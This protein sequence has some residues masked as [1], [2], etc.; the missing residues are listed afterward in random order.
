MLRLIKKMAVTRALKSRCRR[1]GV[2]LSTA[3]GNARPEHTLRNMCNRIAAKRAKK[4]KRG[5]CGGM[6]LQYGGKK[7]GMFGYGK[8]GLSNT[9][10]K[11]QMLKYIK[12]NDP[13]GYG[14]WNVGKLH[15][16][17][18]SIRAT[19]AHSSVNYV[20]GIVQAFDEMYGKNYDALYGLNR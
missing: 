10:V 1:H 19:G 13:I 4:A 2:R 5:G 12:N 6:C 7:R 18:K 9:Q 14:A 11:K 3:S 15:T 20:G 8:N 17:V 16:R